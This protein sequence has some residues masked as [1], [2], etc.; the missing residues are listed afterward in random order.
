MPA[1]SEVLG[2][3]TKQN[4]GHPSRI[5]TVKVD[6]ARFAYV[7][8][9][10]AL[11]HVCN[12]L[13]I[14]AS[15]TKT[16]SLAD[17]VLLY[18]EEWSTDPAKGDS[19]TARLLVQ[20]RDQYGVKLQPIELQEKKNAGDSTWAAGYTKLLAWNQTAYERVLHLDSDGLVLQSMDEL[21]LMPPAPLALPRA[22]WID[23]DERKRSAQIMLVTPSDYEFARVKATMDAGKHDDYDMEIVNTLYQDHAIIIP[24]RPYNLLS[25]EFKAPPQNHK[26]YLGTDEPWDGAK[27]MKEAKYLHFSDWP[28]PKP[29][30]NIP[31]S[32][33]EAHQP[34]CWNTEEGEEKDCR[35][36]DIW[37]KLY[38]DFA[39][40]RK[41]LCGFDL[42]MR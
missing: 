22:Y 42:V 39:K 14:F 36:R 30:F 15:L 20:M 27:I 25:G 10:T 12:A 21:F 41:D 17:K 8:Y 13:M 23:A 26:A 33:F 19:D 35:D 24:H 16:P 11:D 31:K 29:W 7:Q 34:K 1:E 2:K 37:R 5:S 4:V 18:P 40:A 6:W 38:S 32:A 9:A 28:V 3:G